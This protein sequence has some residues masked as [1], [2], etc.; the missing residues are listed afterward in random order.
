MA[1]DLKRLRQVVAIA[2]TRSFARAAQTLALSQPALSRSLQGLEAELGG[3]LFDRGR[4]GATPTPLGERVLA[5]A[6]SLLR[7]A[8]E[9]RRDIDLVLGC[10]AGSLRIGVGPYPASISVGLAV[11]RLIERHPGLEI[12]V[13]V[14]DAESLTRQ[15][16]EAEVDLAVAELTWTNLSD[17]LDVEKLPRHR[18]SFFCRAIHPL[19]QSRELTLED[20]GAFP[21]VATPL[22]ERVWHVLRGT[23]P[24]LEPPHR[25]EDAP[26]RPPIQVN[27]FELIRRIVLECDA[28][29][30]A[31]PAQIAADVRAGSLVALDLE[32]PGLESNYGVITLAGRT[33]SPAA[34]AFIDI[35]QETERELAE[36]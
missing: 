23:R 5:H 8:E 27:S 12:T 19:A 30:L 28:L 17:R 4:G 15:V 36:G 32:V 11:A 34:G 14:N 21:L 13:Q 7:Q 31:T 26:P 33:L 9:A 3:R 6:R 35:L 2:E 10:E 22:P 24:A 29:G 25:L 20:A 18:A 1:L 16:L